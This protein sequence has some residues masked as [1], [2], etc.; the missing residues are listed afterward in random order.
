MLRGDVASSL[1]S[2]Q[3]SLPT[4]IQ[5]GGS[6]DA[7]LRALDDLPVGPVYDPE[8]PFDETLAALEKDLEQLPG[9]LR[10]QARTIG[11]AGTNLRDVG[12]QSV[13]VADAITDVRSSL[14]E[15]ATVLGEYRQTA[16]RA[17]TLLDDTTADL[18]QRLLVLRV[19]VVVLGLVY[20]CGQALPVYLGHRLAESDL[21]VASP[22]P[23]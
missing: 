22:D 23:P 10:E 15:A 3:R 1:E 19:L 18:D 11:R 20:C 12:E 13:E 8:E 21:I 16:G 6:I 5:V 17:R 9:D 14:D 7:T 4:L 2:V